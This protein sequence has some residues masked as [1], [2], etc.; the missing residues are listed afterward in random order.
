MPTTDCISLKTRS[1]AQSNVR[2]YSAP[3]SNTRYGI[4]EIDEDDDD[5][6]DDETSTPAPASSEPSGIYDGDDSSSNDEG[7]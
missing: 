4:Q 7:Y 5:D 6:S 1:N 2:S 3:T